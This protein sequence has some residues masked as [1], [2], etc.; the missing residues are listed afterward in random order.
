MDPSQTEVT[1]SQ[2]DLKECAEVCF[3]EDSSPQKS[4]SELA[5]APQAEVCE[6]K[7]NLPAE[8]KNRDCAAIDQSAALDK[9]MSEASDMSIPSQSATTNNPVTEAAAPSVPSQSATAGKPVTEASN[10]S[11]TPQSATSSGKPVT[12][13]ASPSVHSQSATAGKP[14]TKAAD[15]SVPSQSATAGK[16]VTEAADQSVPSQ[17]ATA[18]KP[19]TEAA[20]PSVPSQSATAGKPVTEA[21]GPSVPLAGGTDLSA[22]TSGTD[23]CYRYEGETCIYTDP[24]SGVDYIYSAEQEGWVRRDGGGGGQPVHAP[25]LENCYYVGEHY[26]FK[27]A[28]GT[29]YR[30]EPESNSWQEWSGPAAAVGDDRC[31]RD[32]DGAWC[33]RDDTGALCR[34]SSAGGRW[35]RVDTDTGSEP[36]AG[37]ERRSGGRKRRLNRGSSDDS[38]HDS[39]DD[40]DDDTDL[41]AAKRPPA[42]VGDGQQEQESP[43][44]GSGYEWDPERGA[45]F[46]KVCM[47]WFFTAVVLCFWMVYVIAVYRQSFYK[48]IGN[49]FTII[50]K[51]HILL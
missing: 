32:A 33:C 1:S 46:P 15:P 6:L 7:Q 28:A 24:S 37:T 3:S 39:D 43:S 44:D 11:I 51:I 19:V 10:P 5:Q 21:A 16:P 12:E 14:V 27:D 49:R 31:F 36:P 34:W 20:D 18:G 4:S 35:V 22:V 17:S 2:S 29:V 9:P 40:G 45:W 30:L 23:D 25:T 47:T 13:A 42:A 41:P 8:E 38:E 50:R 48:F 26:C